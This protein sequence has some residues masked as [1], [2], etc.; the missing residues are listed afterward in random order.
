MKK[1]K[2]LRKILNTMFVLAWLVIL[3]NIAISFFIKKSLT[4]ENLG[5]Y[6]AIS[7]TINGICLFF[8]FIK[9]FTNDYFKE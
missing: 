7:W 2:I 5:N 8:I 3:I 1:R 9:S 4:S 6:F